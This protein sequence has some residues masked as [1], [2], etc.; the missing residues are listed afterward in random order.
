MVGIIQEQHPER[1][2]LFMQW[3]QMGWPILVD[4]LNQLQVQYVPMTFAI[5]EH[6]I[7][8]MINL[9]LSEAE[10][11]KE[12]FLNT[13]YDQ[14][15]DKAVHQTTAPDLKQ[16]LAFTSKGTA[17]AWRRYADALILRGGSQRFDEAIEAYKEALK[18]MPDHNY[19]HFRLG[20]AYRMRYDT[21]Q[22]QTKDFQLAVKHWSKAL[23]IDPNNYIIRRRIQQY[24]PRLDKPYSFYDWVPTAQKEIKARGEKPVTLKVKPG[25]AEFA[26]PITNFE[27]SYVTEEEPDKQGRIDRDRRGFIAIETTVVPAAVV[28]GKSVR[29]HVFLKP[30]NSIKA[31]WNNEVDPLVFWVDPPEGW[32][33]DRRYL[34]VPNPHETVSQE[35]RKVEFETKCPENTKPGP[36]KLPGY[37]L[38]YVC[39]DVNG[40]CLYRRQD[41]EFEIKIRE[42]AP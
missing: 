37:A 39:E 23:D 1:C 26:R 33:V 27:A 42:S 22:S 20:V 17:E 28:P 21:D 15:K 19:T 34:T 14:P 38:Y 36:V 10:E 12:I 29:L 30:N 40:I 24:G 8:R 9:P 18:T 4:P 5:D 35:I 31:H 25:G 6:G 41:V 16:L 11:I 3:K 13:S 7:I 32:Q 2:R